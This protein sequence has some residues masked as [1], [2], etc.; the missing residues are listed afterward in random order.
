MQESISNVG[1]FIFLAYIGVPFLILVGILVMNK[2][3]GANKRRMT[4]KNSVS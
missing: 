4:G 1:I 2:I 3:R